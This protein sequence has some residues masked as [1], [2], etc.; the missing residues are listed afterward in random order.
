MENNF[1]L[2]PAFITQHVNCFTIQ[3]RNL[4]AIS[5]GVTLKEALEDIESSLKFALDCYKTVNG[6]HFEPPEFQHCDI[7]VQYILFS[8]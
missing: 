5:V 3:I 8:Y 7:A 2:Y 6:V 1:K 4:P